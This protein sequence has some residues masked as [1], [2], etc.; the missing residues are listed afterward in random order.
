[1]NHFARTYLDK[2]KLDASSISERC[3]PDSDGEDVNEDGVKCTK[4]RFNDY[5]WENTPH[6]YEPRC[7]GWYGDQWG[8]KYSTFGTVYLF[9]SGKPGIT[10]CVPLWSTNQDEYKGAYCLDQFPTAEDS[11]FV[12]KYYDTDDGAIVNYLIF[13]KDDAFNEGRYTES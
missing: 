7:R 3:L 12:R 10:N 4:Y 6:H 1:M 2:D 5:R 11:S 8:K 13:N 9:A